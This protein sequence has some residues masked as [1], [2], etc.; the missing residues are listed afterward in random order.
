MDDDLGCEWKFGEARSG[1][2]CAPFA[3]GRLLVVCLKFSTTAVAAA[4]ELQWQN[5]A[6]L[7]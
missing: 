5:A 1:S 2:S 6:L 4:A 7:F 3:L